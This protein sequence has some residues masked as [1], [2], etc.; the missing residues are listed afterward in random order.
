MFTSLK[1]IGICLWE[2]TSKLML[3]H[4]LTRM[5]EA[6]LSLMASKLL[7]THSTIIYLASLILLIASQSMLMIQTLKN[8]I[9]TTKSINLQIKYFSLRI[10]MI[11]TSF[12][13]RLKYQLMRII[14]KRSNFI[15][16]FFK[17]EHGWFKK[18]R[19]F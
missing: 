6:L 9:H 2:I 10:R 14:Q 19:T 5:V 1:I 4:Q 18:D 12:H 17:R 8:N 15:N 11:D 13:I 7:R 3:W 16:A